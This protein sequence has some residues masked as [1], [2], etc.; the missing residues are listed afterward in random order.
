LRVF[1]ERNNEDAH[2]FFQFTDGCV[3]ANGAR[4][5]ANPS[6][7]LTMHKY[8]YTRAFFFSRGPI[9]QGLMK[10]AQKSRYDLIM[11]KLD[12]FFATTK[13]STNPLFLN[14]SHE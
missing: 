2:V 9:C 7:N 14:R 4:Q 3:V 12:T 1:V 11:I 6:A 10:V 5:S 8:T 13:K